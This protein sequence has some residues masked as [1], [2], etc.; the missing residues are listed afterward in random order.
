VHS[1]F[2]EASTAISRADVRS[3]TPVKLIPVN[4]S[5]TAISSAGE[6]SSQESDEE[7]DQAVASKLTYTSQQV[8]KTPAPRPLILVTKP[9]KYQ[10]YRTTTQI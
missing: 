10:H 5:S 1:V 7:A 4:K 3:K 6:Q 2:S 9:V 8:D